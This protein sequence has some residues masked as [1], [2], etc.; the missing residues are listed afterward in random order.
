[1]VAV[2]MNGEPLPAAHG[3]PARI[4]VPGL[5]GYVSATK[6]LAEIELTSFAAVD[7]YWI[8][9]GWSKEGPIKTQSRIDVVSR[10]VIAG[11]AWAPTRG[12][13]RVEVQVDGASWRVAKLAEPVNDDCWRQW[14]MPWDAA[15]GR[16]VIA[17]RATD[18]TGETQTAERTEVAPNGA[19]GHHTVQV[20]IA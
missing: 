10:Q 5:Y 14:F 9:R 1:M 18:G 17:V 8:P 4:V 6:W 16:R 13:E 15:P 19:S 7:G 12:I 11:V 2:A 20:D 3:F